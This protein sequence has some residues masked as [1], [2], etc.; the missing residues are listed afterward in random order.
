MR[1]GQWQ[2]RTAGW[3]RDYMTG[4]RCRQSFVSCSRSTNGAARWRAPPWVLP[5]VI[6]LLF[7][8]VACLPA[9]AVAAGVDAAANSI[10]IA[11]STEPP[12]LDSSLAEDSA[13]AFVLG[14]TNEGLVR[15]DGRGRLRPAV[16]E[17]WELSASQATFHLRANAQWSDGKPVT[18]TDFVFA[19]RRLVDPAT[20]A[21][22]STVFA[23]RIANGAEALAGEVE[24]AALGVSAPDA[25]TLIV[26]LA[27]PTPYFVR[28]MAAP[29]Y[30]P[31]RADFL[32]VKGDAYAAG[33]EDLLS[34]GPFVLEQWVH[35]ASLTLRRNKAYWDARRVALAGLDVGYVTSDSRALFNLYRSG[36]IAEVAIDETTLPEV[37]R[38]KLRLRRNPTNC[39]ALLTFNFREGHITRDPR[40]R[41]AVRL[42]FDTE[43]YI[44]RVI[45]VPGNKPLWSMFSTHTRALEGRFIDVYPPREPITDRDAASALVDEVRREVGEL[46]RLVLLAT[47]GNEKRDEYIQAQLA[48]HLG[49]EVLLDR[50]TFKQA[51]VKLIAGDFDIAQSRFCSGTLTD[52]VFFAEIFHSKGT[53]NDGRYFNERYDRLVERA[54]LEP[55]A[56]ARMDLFGKMQSILIDDNVVLPTHEIGQVYLQDRRLRG[57]HRFPV[58]SFA[59]GRIAGG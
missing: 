58:R 37:G 49:L 13:S 42:A 50:Q 47:E 40:V 56:A 57:L 20:G 43:E 52:P 28:L 4:N 16:A 5:V 23:N 8:T 31:L 22:G 12:T 18:A 10:T 15:F 45:A 3:W 29:A 54:R 6:N 38:A 46:P 53:F 19:F 34:N 35:G 1:C 7:A 59:F 2:K 41:R 27:R 32:A 36:E 26:D 33:A 11:I 14:M 44:D 25:R 51:I 24:P 39:V 55:D 30:F 48:R 17:S 9:P 21:S